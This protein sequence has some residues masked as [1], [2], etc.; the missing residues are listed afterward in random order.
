MKRVFSQAAGLLWKSS[1]AILV[2]LAATVVSA[3][4]LFG[5]AVPVPAVGTDLPAWYGPSVMLAAGKGFVTPTEN[6][7]PAELNEFLQRKRTQ[8]DPAVLSDYA[9]LGTPGAFEHVHYY[10][11]HAVGLFWRVFGISWDR[12]KIMLAV[13]SG[14]T[15]LMAYGILRLGMNRF[16]AV[17]GALLYTASP[18]L[19]TA[20]ASIRDFCKAPFILAAILIL[21]YMVKN[22]LTTRK[23]M[24]LAALQGFVLA[25]GLG[26]RQDMLVVLYISAVV[27]AFAARCDGKR[28]LL[29]RLGALAVMFGCFVLP[30][31]PMLRNMSHMEGPFH[32]ITMGLATICEYNLGLQRGSYEYLQSML[33]VYAGATRTSFEE[34][35]TQKPRVFMYASSEDMEAARDFAVE[36]AT[37]FP[38]DMLTR[39]YAAVARILGDTAAGFSPPYAGK[40]DNPD[41]FIAHA[42]HIWVPVGIFLDR[43]SVYL[44][45]IALVLI[46][47]QSPILAWTALF[48]GIC[49]CG[50]ASIAFSS[51]HYFHLTFAGLLPIGLLLDQLTQ[52]CM[53]IVSSQGRSEVRALFTDPERPWVAPLR[54]MAVFSVCASVL[55]FGTLYAARVYQVR[56]VGQ[57]LQQC[58]SAK[59]EP[60]AYEQMPSQGRIIVHPTSLDSTPFGETDPDAPAECR[61]KAS[62]VVAEFELHGEP[63]AMDV[64]YESSNSYA[65]F[66]SPHNTKVP[67]GATS[68]VVRYFIPVYELTPCRMCQPSRFLGIRIGA[69]NVQDLRALYKVSNVEQFR[70]LLNLTLPPDLEQFQRYHKVVVNGEGLPRRL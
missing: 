36:V 16:W 53:R 9:S 34:R 51:R 20:T 50:Y 6:G 22:T 37:T 11:L 30:A 3:V 66:S 2:C 59:L 62:Y 29:K 61:I 33:D 68:G 44:A 25:I 32:H 8:L 15:V 27:V 42:R 23:L 10:L 24:G 46:S 35:A 55:L 63:P 38:G 58:T 48:L 13:F 52:C 69:K 49:F 26:F 18:L 60:L 5:W 54:R 7:M 64:V 39:V 12:L 67:G 56:E 41:P 4:Y 43:Y 57:Y 45:A 40:A 70:L 19:L 28:R 14:L 21:G 17:A 1:C 47:S 65:D 31:Q